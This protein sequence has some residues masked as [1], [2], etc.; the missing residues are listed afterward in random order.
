MLP[1]HIWAWLHSTRALAS[2]PCTPWGACRA[3][4]LGRFPRPLMCNPVGTT[5]W[6]SPIRP[7]TLPGCRRHANLAVDT[8]V[9]G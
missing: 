4:K 8:F 5:S 6:T 9:T 1:R 3:I 2:V 7:V